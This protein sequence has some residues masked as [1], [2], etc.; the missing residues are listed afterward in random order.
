MVSIFLLHPH[1]GALDIVLFQ[2][3]EFLESSVIRVKQKQ[4]LD[5]Q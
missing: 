3:F 2:S 1:N 5:R 4:K